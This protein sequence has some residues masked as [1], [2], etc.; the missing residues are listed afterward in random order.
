SPPGRK[1]RRS[2]TGPTPRHLRTPRRQT[3]RIRLRRMGRTRRPAMVR[4]HL[5]RMGRTRRPAT[6]RT[7]PHR[8]GRIPRPATARTPRRQTV[9]IRLRQTGRT[10]RVTVR[11]RLI[12]G[13]A[14]PR[15]NSKNPE[16]PHPLNRR[17][18]SPWSSPRPRPRRRTSP[19]NRT[20]PP[21]RRA[22]TSRTTTRRRGSRSPRRAPRPRAP[23]PRGSRSRPRIRVG[24][25]PRVAAIDCGTNSIR[26]LVA[27]LTY[28]HDGSVDLR[29]LHREMRIV[30]LGQG[31]D[32]TGKLAPEALERTREALKAYAIAARRKGVERLRM[33]ATSA[34]RDASN[35]DEFFTMTRELLGTEAEVITGEEEARLSFT[36]AVGEQDPDDGP[37]LVVDV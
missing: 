6:A 1:H 18:N 33:V 30:R 26:L 17:G 10:R 12:R 35:R 13:G 34:T 16:N 5:R 28:R 24:S 4:T 2:R 27:E 21:T 7:R 15:K 9:R 29:D 3:V 23:R 11:T 32:A 36:G 8:M 19:P 25:M 20:S 22:T 31:V 14:I 37:F